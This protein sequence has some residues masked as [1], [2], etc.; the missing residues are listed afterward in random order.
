MEITNSV[1]KWSLIFLVVII[2]LFLIASRFGAFSFTLIFSA[3]IASLLLF[4]NGVIVV[5]ILRKMKAAGMPEFFIKKYIAASLIKFL[6]VIL[7]SAGVFYL[8][9]T[10]KIPV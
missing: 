1:R 9:Q 3:Y 8:L 4:N 2:S 7:V 5:L 6:A 10:G